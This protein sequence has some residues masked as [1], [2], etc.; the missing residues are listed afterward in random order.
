[1]QLLA[2]E[3]AMVSMCSSA[4]DIHDCAARKA[5]PLQESCLREG[6]EQF[7]QMQTVLAHA[8][9]V[10]TIGQLAASIPHEL[11]QPITAMTTNAAAALRWL[12]SRPLDLESIRHSLV[13]IVKNGSRVRDVVG[14][15]RALIRKAPPRRERLAIDKAIREVIELTHG[16]AVKNDVLVRA[17]LA[18]DLPIMHGDRVQLQQVILNLVINAIEA[19]SNVSEGARELLVTASKAGAGVLVTVR[20]SGPGLAQAT[21]ERV[22]D[23]FYTTKPNGLGL[24][25]SICRSIIEAHGGRLWASANTP[26]GAVFQFTLGEEWC[27]RSVEIPS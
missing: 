17:E 2:K 20:D 9:R 23:P 21:M 25:L 6:D 1:M 13:A 26:S 4:P 24:G 10:T 16:E 3:P 18:D 7:R 11:S 27:D 8:N 12:D 22:F 19:V 14:C 5:P 15:M